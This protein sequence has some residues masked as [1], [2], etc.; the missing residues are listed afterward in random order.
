[1]RT[2]PRLRLAAAA[3]WLAGAFSAGAFTLD[4]DPANA[5]ANLGERLFLETRF[6]QF[7]FTHCG[8][9]VNAIVP[10]IT[11]A[12]YAG[13]EIIAAGGTNVVLTNGDPVM[14]TLQTI[15]GPQPGPFAGQSM[16][17]RQCHLVNEMQNSRGTNFL[18]NRTY[19]DFATRSPIPDRGDGSVVTPR[20]ASTLVNALVGRNG[21]LFLHWDGQFATA[22][23]LVLETL[24]GRNYGW[25]PTEYA[26]A[27]HHIAN[28]IRND[29]GHGALANSRY[30]GGY[31]YATMFTFPPQE[32]TTFYRLPTQYWLGDLAET[33]T[34]GPF[35]VSDDEIV[36]TVAALIVEYMDTLVFS[37]DTNGVFNGSPY[38]VFLAKNGLPRKPMD[39]ETPLQYSQRLLGLIQELAHPQC[40]SDPADGHF[41]TLKQKFQFGAMELEGLSIFLQTNRTGT[42]PAPPPLVA[43]AS[44]GGNVTVS[45]IPAAGR[46]FA[47]PDAGLS[48]DWKPVA[49]H[50]P[51]VVPAGARAMF[52]KVAA[53]ATINVA[54]R[55]GNCAVCHPPP[56]FTDFVFHNTGVS[57]A[58]Y[59]SVH[60]EGAFSRVWIPDLAT[61]QSNYDAYLPPTTNHPDATG[62][63]RL[64]PTRTNAGA[65]DLGLWNVFDNPDYPA[66]QAAL[67]QVL[68]G[69]FPYAVT[70]DA[71]LQS[72]I[73]LV[74]T[75]T[76]RDLGQSQPYLHTGQMRTIEDVI[77]FD[78]EFSRKARQGAVRNGD[79]QLQYESVDDN[80]V[81]PLGAFLRALNEDYTD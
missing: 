67:Q 59:D 20:N 62:R 81:A 61:R 56:D 37:Q 11:N 53:P 1:M 60:G 50:P 55:A 34:D 77:Q 70:A 17:C 33:N 7:F 38:D 36:Q 32:I 64:P 29:N 6:A 58:D 66:P 15:Y 26:T 43:I 24:T 65:M 25:Q 68:T 40:V 78:R 18:G 9:D 21:P 42:V 47:S 35:Y 76:L 2:S 16:N 52:F 10:N 30:G 45:W 8:G 79:P 19:C 13:G 71:L 48:A 46:L 4:D 27:V 73:G 72:T 12:D 69:E 39:G 23:E 51:Y 57:Q 28:V 54:G 31:P 5:A 63:F 49:D 74:K 44:A 75:P 14:A 80:A 3:L 22:Q 41:L